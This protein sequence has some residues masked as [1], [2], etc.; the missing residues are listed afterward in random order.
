MPRMI[1]RRAAALAVLAFVPAL[2]RAAD[3]PKPVAAEK[4]SYYQ[5]VRPIFQAHCQ[6]C[7]QPA[8]ARGDFVMTAFDKLLAG[9]ESG[10]KAVVP[11]HPEQSKLVAD[12]TPVDGKAKMPEGKPPLDPG[13]IDLIRRWVAE[14]AVD[15]TPANARERYSLD[16]P[17]VYTRPPVIATLDF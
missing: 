4:V 1:L 3:A 14:G 12:I 9:G 8:K 17:P 13:D 11:Q 16:K 10:Q 7:H 15:D 6:G 2:A 5:Q